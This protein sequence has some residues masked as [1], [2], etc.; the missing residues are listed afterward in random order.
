[1]NPPL[2]IVFPLFKR[3]TYLDFMGPLEALAMLP[4]AQVITASVGGAP[5][6]ENNLTLSN[7]VPL[8][9]LERCDVLC[10]PG[11]IDVSQAV[12]DETYLAAIRRLAST[13]R[14]VTSV[15]TGSLILGA[16]G[17]LEGRRAAC[18]WLMR[19]SLTLFGAIPDA[20][21]VVRDGNI[22]TGG[23]VTAGIDFALTLAAELAGPAI[24]QTIQV[25][26]E[27]APEPPFNAGRPET[28]P[29]ECVAF[30]RSKEPPEHRAQ[31]QRAADALHRSRPS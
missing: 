11:S 16:A 7:L 22:L 17:L 25:S 14:Y 9:S 23:G 8:E 20:G 6:R 3:V 27:Y 2:V 28:A 15:C 30:V 4:G 29:A 31:L 10:V 5:I 26:L 12:I 18:H 21:R 19:D 24:A 1:M 13:A